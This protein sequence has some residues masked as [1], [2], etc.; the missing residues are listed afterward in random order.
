VPS[1]SQ[2]RAFFISGNNVSYARLKSFDKLGILIV[3]N[4]GA[5]MK[6]QH[7]LTM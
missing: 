6:P 1:A 2:R 3:F 7:S 5:K 4:A